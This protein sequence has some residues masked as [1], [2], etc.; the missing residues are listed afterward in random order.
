[1]ESKLCHQ[2]LNRH[3]T[4]RGKLKQVGESFCVAVL[5]LLGVPQEFFVFFGCE[6]TCFAFGSK[7]TKMLPK[8]F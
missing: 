7:G 3:P 8:G 1:M 4:Q 6:G 2:C 5:R